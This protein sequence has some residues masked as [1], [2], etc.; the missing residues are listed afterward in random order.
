MLG[1]KP[2]QSGGRQ[3][4]L[5]SQWALLISWS[6]TAGI[7]G[8][9]QA[10]KASR[11]EDIKLAYQIAIE[12]G[13]D[14]TV[15][16]RQPLNAPIVF[17]ILGADGRPY[18]DTRVSFCLTDV[19]NLPFLD[20][21]LLTLV[22]KCQVDKVTSSPEV[23]QGGVKTP[24]RKT[25]EDQ[26]GAILAASE[27]TDGQ[28]IASIRVRSPGSYAKKIG[29]VMYLSEYLQ[30]NVGIVA[31]FSTMTFGQREMFVLESSGSGQETAGK[32]FNL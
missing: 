25:P 18:V 2:T 26:V 17:R 12:S 10:P 9:R 7:S 1:I 8:C 6:L 23:G 19:T 3:V 14:Q 15:P 16:P 31:T 22:Q 5:W 28:G 32:N 24:E 29:V 21:P 27:R 13:Q 20:Q 11:S 4:P 30:N